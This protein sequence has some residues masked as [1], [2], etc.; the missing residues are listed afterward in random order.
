[1]TNIEKRDTLQNHN[2]SEPRPMQREDKNA[3]WLYFVSLLDFLRGSDNL[4]NLESVA[5]WNYYY[6]LFTQL[7]NTFYLN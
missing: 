3:T 7:T 6:C 2:L 1:M 5:C 4:L